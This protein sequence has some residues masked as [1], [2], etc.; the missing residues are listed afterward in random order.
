MSIRIKAIQKLIHINEALF[1]YPSLKKFY[2]K[3]LPNNE[4]HILDVGANKGQ[5]IDFFLNLNKKSNIESFVPNKKMFAYLLKKYKSN[6]NIKLYDFGVSHK[7]GELLFHENIL[8]ETSTF[9]NL[10]FKS[11]YLLKKAKA[12]NTSIENIIVKSYMVK[13]IR[14]I[15]FLKSNP[16]TYYDILKIDVEGHELS[17]LKGLFVDNA[18]VPI[19]LIQLESHNDDMYIN[20]NQHQEIEKLMLKNGFIQIAKIKH[21]FGDFNELI[22]KNERI[23][24][25]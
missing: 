5:S 16:A 7:E 1:F 3:E 22:F 13:T 15:D 4:L 9:E 17:C 25:A 8:D 11:E 2:K 6:P 14:L 19:G 24:E 12:L 20:N 21:R 18:N 10:N 23:N